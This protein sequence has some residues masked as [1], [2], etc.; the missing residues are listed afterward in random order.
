MTS[1]YQHEGPFVTIDLATDGATENAAQKIELR[2]RD[3]RR[4][5]ADAGVDE[6]TREALTAALGAEPHRQGGTRV[7][8]AAGGAGDPVRLAVS[9]PDAQIRF[10]P[11]DTEDSPQ[12]GVGALLR[13]SNEPVQATE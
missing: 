8:I 3:V 5:L 7:L 9:L 11:G 13:Y 10:V 4:E 12:E 1:L 2:W 6:T